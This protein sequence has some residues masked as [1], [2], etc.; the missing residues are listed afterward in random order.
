MYLSHYI[1]I[2]FLCIN[3]FVQICQF[4]LPVMRCS[5]YPKPYLICNYTSSSIQCVVPAGT[6]FGA[7]SSCLSVSFLLLWYGVSSGTFIFLFFYSRKGNG[8]SLDPLVLFYKPYQKAKNYGDDRATCTLIGN[9]ATWMNRSPKVN[10]SSP[11]WLMRQ[12]T[13]N[14]LLDDL[15]KLPLRDEVQYLLQIHC[16]L[17]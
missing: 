2:D 10:M 13:R 9:M 15:L 1:F 7:K 17:L 16:S 14:R 5:W 6:T 8:S 4:I 3:A 11:E 12:Q